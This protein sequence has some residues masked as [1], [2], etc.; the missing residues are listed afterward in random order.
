MLP[1]P[2]SLSRITVFNGLIYPDKDTYISLMSVILGQPLMIRDCRLSGMA[3][4]FNDR[5]FV[6]DNDVILSQ[7][8]ISSVSR[9]AYESRDKDVISV[10]E[11]L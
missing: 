7:P 11:R 1:I 2:S 3:M 9:W 10:P 6:N 4:S 8:E 5:H